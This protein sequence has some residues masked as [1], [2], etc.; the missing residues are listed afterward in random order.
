VRGVSSRVAADLQA[1]GFAGAPDCSSESAELRAETARELGIRSRLAGPRAG[2]AA[3][4]KFLRVIG[5]VLAIVAGPVLASLIE[6]RLPPPAQ[7][8]SRLHLRGSI[9]FNSELR[10]RGS[11]R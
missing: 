2:K 1:S 11:I 4:A 6:S 9:A 7:Y 5:T 10:L 3:V 8:A